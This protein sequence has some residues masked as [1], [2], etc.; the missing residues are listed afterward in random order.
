[1]ACECLEDLLETLKDDIQTYLDDK[2]NIEEAKHASE[3][4]DITIPPDSAY[5]ITNN[6]DTIPELPFYPAIV[7]MGWNE[8]VVLEGEQLWDLWKADVAVRIYMSGYSD[9][10]TLSKAFYRFS[11]AVLKVIRDEFQDE[12][13]V[14]DVTELRMDYSAVTPTEPLFQASEISFKVTYA[15]SYS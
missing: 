10:E 3:P 6:V 9:Q 7:I 11:H 5:F 15:R 4:I 14:A 1:M 13:D 8:I 12:E 2:L